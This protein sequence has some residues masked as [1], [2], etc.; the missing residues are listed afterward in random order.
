MSGRH[1]YQSPREDGTNLHRDG[2]S[3]CG[4]FT[5]SGNKFTCVDCLQDLTLNLTDVNI[6]HIVTGDVICG[7]LDNL[8]W[9]VVKSVPIDDSVMAAIN[10]IA[11]SGSW[12]KMEANTLR[13]QKFNINSKGKLL[14]KWKQTLISFLMSLK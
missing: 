12:E 8:G 3:I 6:N 14:K 5:D 7:D 4:C 2:L 10:D 9:A 11:S 1:K 13:R